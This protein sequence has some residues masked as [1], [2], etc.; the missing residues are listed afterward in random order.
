M[1]SA[2]HL[3]SSA[4]VL[5]DAHLL[6]DTH[7]VGRSPLK[8]SCLAIHQD[9]NA[10]PRQLGTYPTKR[11]KNDVKNGRS[12]HISADCVVLDTLRCPFSH[13]NHKSRDVR[14]SNRAKKPTCAT[15]SMC[16]GSNNSRMILTVDGNRQGFRRNVAQRSDTLTRACNYAAAFAFVPLSDVHVQ[17]RKKTP[18]ST[19]HE[20]LQMVV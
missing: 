7:Q 17:Q 5:Y 20:C 9:K 16:D 11:H 3:L 13:K 2:T 12:C 8:T 6:S 19:G 4:H 14:D 18:S 15:V 1:L 10:Q